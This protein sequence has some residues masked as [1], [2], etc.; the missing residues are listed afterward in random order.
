MSYGVQKSFADTD[1]TKLMRASMNTTVI[2]YKA[3]QRYHKIFDC[4]T[5]VDPL[6]TI[7]F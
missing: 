7:N 1:R 3:T 2:T 5:V 6:K 4:I